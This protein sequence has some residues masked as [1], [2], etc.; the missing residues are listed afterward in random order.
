MMDP[1]AGLLVWSLTMHSDAERSHSADKQHLAAERIRHALPPRPNFAA[2]VGRAWK[3]FMG[4]AR[5]SPEP[6]AMATQL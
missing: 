3:A 4:T 5:P 6:P 2:K 1:H